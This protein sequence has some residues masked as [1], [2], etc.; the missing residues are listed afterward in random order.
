MPDDERDDRI[1]GIHIGKHDV[2]VDGILPGHDAAAVGPGIGVAVVHVD[3]VPRL[4]E[5][6]FP[7]CQ[8]DI[9]I[10]RQQVDH[11]T[12]KSG[13]DA[14]QIRDRRPVRGSERKTLPELQA[15]RR[16]GDALVVDPQVRP[17]EQ[18]KIRARGIL[19]HLSGGLRFVVRHPL[20][21]LVRGGNTVQELLPLPVPAD[22]TR[23][24]RLRRTERGE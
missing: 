8:L 23:G 12:D 18:L 6:R 19:P 15:G 20:L 24:I 3:V 16:E 7:H 2:E 5:R 11:R 14:A 9:S 22:E 4:C 21:P 10:E 13:M 1:G 17:G